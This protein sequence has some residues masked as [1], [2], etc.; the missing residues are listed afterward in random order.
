MYFVERDVIRIKAYLEESD[1]IGKGAGYRW[2]T[3]MSAY[4]LARV[5]GAIGD[6]ETARAKFLESANIANEFGNKRIVY[7]SHS[8]LAHVLREHGEI[9]EPLNIY[10]ELLPKW[11]D[12]GHR[13]AVAHELECIAFILS[14]KGDI[15]RAAQLLGAAEALRE[16]IDSSMTT[17]EQAEYDREVSALRSKMNEIDFEKAWNEGREMTMDEAIENAFRD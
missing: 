11:K 6:L 1:S 3:S 5:A 4:G 7:S 2:T 14:K 9:D 13:A 15:Q 10:R 8:E 17:L 12:L 16:V